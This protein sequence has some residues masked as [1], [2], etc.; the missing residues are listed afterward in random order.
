MT[1]YNNATCA[2]MWKGCIL[3]TLGHTWIVK[4]QITVSGKKDNLSDI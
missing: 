2:P 1:D 3:K 4:I